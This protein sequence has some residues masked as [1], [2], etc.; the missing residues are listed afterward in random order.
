MV[1]HLSLALLVRVQAV[2]DGAT[3][4]LLGEA[5]E[6]SAD[7]PFLGVL[8]QLTPV[9]VVALVLLVL[10]RQRVLVRTA[11][12]LARLLLLNLAL[13]RRRSL[14]VLVGILDALLDGFFLRQLCG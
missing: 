10:L 11:H 7:L 5:L 13:I 14:R 6:G 12:Q 4:R 2:D 8:L 3:E 9:A 1:R